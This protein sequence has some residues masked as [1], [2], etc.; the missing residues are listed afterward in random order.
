MPQH[1]NTASFDPR[2]G[3]ELDVLHH[4]LPE[5]ALESLARE[6]ITRMAPS[7][8]PRSG[9]PILGE[10]E[11]S[12]FCDALLAPGPDAAK[13]AFEALRARAATFSALYLDLLTPAAQRLGQMWENDE[14]SFIEVSMG[15]SRIYGI[16][17]D[18]RDLHLV[19]GS[20]GKPFAIFATLPGEE[21]T[22]GAT[23]AADLF[24]ERGWDVDLFVGLDHAAVVDAVDHSSAPIL[25]I[26]AAQADDLPALLRLLMAVH[27]HRPSL[28]VFV[29][30]NIVGDLPEIDTFVGIDGAAREFE[31]AYRGISDLFEE[32]S[33]PRP[34]ASAST[35]GHADRH[36][37]R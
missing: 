25:G 12:D 6:V 9:A 1:H 4:R 31:E 29:A 7:G 16:L 10:T 21:H 15:I 26:S 30:G 37:P 22:L 20:A 36:A 34:A 23:M 13:R 33:A 24:R 3:L 32:V 11:V 35:G 28:R 18:L 8:R 5:D 17:Y 19:S 2:G 27:V 14:A